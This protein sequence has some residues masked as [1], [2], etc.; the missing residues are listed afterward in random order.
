M[1]IEERN[2]GNANV[3][4]TI[5]NT[6]DGFDYAVHVHDAADPNTTPNGTPYN[7]TPNGNVFAGV[8]SGKFCK[9]YKSNRS[10]LPGVGK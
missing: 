9:F 5:N 3:S 4:V 2:N 1:T 6:L 10:E 7:E 8:I